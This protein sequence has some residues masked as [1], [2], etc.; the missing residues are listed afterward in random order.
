LFFGGC[1]FRYN[2]DILAPRVKYCNLDSLLAISIRRR[3]GVINDFAVSGDPPNMNVPCPVSTLYC[4]NDD[5]CRSISGTND[6]SRIIYTATTD[7]QEIPIGHRLDTP[8][9][10]GTVC[11]KGKYRNQ[12]KQRR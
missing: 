4:P 1:L 12:H 11:N 6:S 7:A 9:K 3:T 5:S 10:H 8:G 2:R